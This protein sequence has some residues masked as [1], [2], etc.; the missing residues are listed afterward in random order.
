[1][2]KSSLFNHLTVRLNSFQNTEFNQVCYT[3]RTVL[4]YR[5]GGT[6]LDVTVLA[7]SG[8]MYR[9]VATE[10][11]TTLGGIKF[12]ELLSQHL[13]AEFQRFLH[14]SELFISNLSL[15][16]LARF[17]ISSVKSH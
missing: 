17:K 12:D 16:E 8:G 1:M 5:L 15:K 7:V 11:D 3:L 2:V 14:I 9:V 6:T 10:H 4:V 13:A